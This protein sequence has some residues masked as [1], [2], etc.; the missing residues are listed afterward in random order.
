MLDEVVVTRSRSP[1]AIDPDE[2]GDIAVDVFG[3]DRVHVAPRLDDAVDVAFGRAE[4]GGLV[5]GG[6]L[7]TGSITL[8]ADVRRLLLR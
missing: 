7:A 1:R 6:V 2:L 8:A 4:E 3:E 5:G